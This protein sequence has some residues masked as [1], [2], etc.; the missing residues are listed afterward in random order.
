M[1]AE[2]KVQTLAEMVETAEAEDA[3]RKAGVDYA[4]GWLYGR[5]SEKPMDQAQITAFLKGGAGAGSLAIRAAAEKRK[6]W[7]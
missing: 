6:E 1:C 5:A 3:V 7:G 2:L 4:Q